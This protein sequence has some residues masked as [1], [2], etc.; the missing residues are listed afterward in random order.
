MRAGDQGPEKWVSYANLVVPD[1]AGAVPPFE[2]RAIRR[3]LSRR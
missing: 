2:R 3:C 1:M